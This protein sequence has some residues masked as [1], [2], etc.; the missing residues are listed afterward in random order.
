MGAEWKMQSEREEGPITNTWHGKKTK[1]EEGEKKQT[2]G[3]K[4]TLKLH[5]RDTAEDIQITSWTVSAK[6]EQY[7]YQPHYLEQL[8]SP[9]FVSRVLWGLGLTH[10]RALA[11]S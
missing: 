11:F 8:S 1:K 3:K 6:K 2:K 5:R 10:L 7:Q 4:I 9:P